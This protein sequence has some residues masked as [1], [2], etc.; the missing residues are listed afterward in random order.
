MN[1]LAIS[2]SLRA[3]SSNAAALSALQLLA[4]PDVR[5]DLCNKISLLPLFNPDLDAPGLA[6]P[7]VAADFRND[8]GVSHGLVI[9]SPE[10]AHGVPGALKNALDWLVS[11][12][13]FADKPV[14]VLSIS[15][16]SRHSHAQ[17]HE[18]LRTMSASITD[19]AAYSVS[20]SRSIKDA[21]EIL[22]DST[23][24]TQLTNAI[25]IFAEYASHTIAS[26]P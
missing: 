8:V 20:I 7:P 22:S 24:S 1:L 6:L 2:G 25:K 14:M 18:V 3:K 9:S 5:I 26:S 12:E 16:F 23:L 17:L 13:H 10:Y 11:S 19:D 15:P 21:S 4:P